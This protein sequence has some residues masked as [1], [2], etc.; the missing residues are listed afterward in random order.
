MFGFRDQASKSDTGAERR[1]GKSGVVLI[2]EPEDT[3]TV[4]KFL[5]AKEEKSGAVKG[6]A[7]HHVMQRLDFTAADTVR[8]VEAQLLEL[9]KKKQIREEEILLLNIP[10][11]VHFSE[12]ISGNGRQM[13]PEEVSFIAKNSL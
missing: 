12:P 1:T 4:P 2:K 5:E 9:Q 11:I 10:A 13:R 3:A 7:M 8:Q 6:T